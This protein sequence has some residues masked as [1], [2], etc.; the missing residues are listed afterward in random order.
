MGLGMLKE[1]LPTICSPLCQV[2]IPAG[3]AEASRNKTKN[4]NDVRERALNHTEKLSCA[5]NAL[6]ACEA[7]AFD[8]AFGRSRQGSLVWGSFPKKVQIAPGPV[9]SQGWRRRSLSTGSLAKMAWPKAGDGPR[10]RVTG[11]YRGAF[12][13]FRTPEF[14]GPY[15]VF[16]SFRARRLLT[17]GSFHF[18]L[19]GVNATTSRPASWAG[20][21]GP[22]V[23]AS[24]PIIWSLW[25]SLGVRVRWAVISWG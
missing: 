24:G 19:N 7:R 3:K 25:S 9:R 17:F 5:A 16:S 8:K 20:E 11:S 6:F 2:Q 14:L 13:P 12:V 21:E 23:R 22:T 1:S 10:S 15:Y 4:Y 18:W